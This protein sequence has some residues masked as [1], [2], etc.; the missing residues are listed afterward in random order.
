MARRVLDRMWIEGGLAVATKPG[1]RAD[2]PGRSGASKV[3]S[4]DPEPGRI[5]S[6]PERLAAWLDFRTNRHPYGA[7]VRRAM[8]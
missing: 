1:A 6:E 5:D 8:A 3:G 7:R 4:L 2:P